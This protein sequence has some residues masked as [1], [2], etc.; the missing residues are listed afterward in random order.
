MPRLPARWL[1]LRVCVC[2]CKPLHAPRTSEVG[3]LTPLWSTIE[4]GSS[5]GESRQA[6]MSGWGSAGEGNVSGDG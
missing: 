4:L 5:I 1:A 3:G 2:P 6:D